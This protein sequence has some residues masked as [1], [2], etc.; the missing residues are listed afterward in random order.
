MTSFV[1]LMHSACTSP[2][3]GRHR[4]DKCDAAVRAD[5]ILAA[6]ATNDASAPSLARPW[7]M[8][9]EKDKVNGGNDV[10]RPQLDR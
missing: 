10:C 9:E 1:M 2:S 3:L 5:F 6:A 8:R 4:R 7:Q